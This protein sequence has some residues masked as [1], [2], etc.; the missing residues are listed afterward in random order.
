[1][2][3]SLVGDVHI[4][5]RRKMKMPRGIPGQ[6]K[7]N[8]FKHSRRPFHFSKASAAVFV[9]IGEFLFKM[10]ALFKRLGGITEALSVWDCFHFIVRIV[11]YLAFFTIIFSYFFFERAGRLFL[12]YY[13]NFNEHL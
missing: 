7:K 3:L 4:L 12:F 1:M 11:R 5:A 9:I 8:A 13:K 6:K 2:Y 10:K